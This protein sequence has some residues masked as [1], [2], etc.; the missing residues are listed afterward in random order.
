MSPFVTKIFQD[1]TNN[2]R[3]IFNAVNNNWSQR[4]RL[5]RMVLQVFSMFSRRLEQI[6]TVSIGLS[7]LSYRSTDGIKSSTGRGI[8]NRK[9]H[10]QKLDDNYDDPGGNIAVAVVVV[11]VVAVAVVVCGAD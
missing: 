9:R 4:R 6:C 10:F 1:N 7:K 11:V 5:S 8:R 2:R 3:N